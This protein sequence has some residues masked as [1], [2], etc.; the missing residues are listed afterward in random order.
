M[1]VL[2]NIYEPVYFRYRVGLVYG[3]KMKMEVM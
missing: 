3:M 1:L 2:Q